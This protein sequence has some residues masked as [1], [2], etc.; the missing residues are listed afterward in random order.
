MFQMPIEELI[1]LFYGLIFMPYVISPMVKE[2]YSNDGERI[3]EY[4]DHHADNVKF[5]LKKLIVDAN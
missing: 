5:M 2:L 4:Y 3:A 1:T